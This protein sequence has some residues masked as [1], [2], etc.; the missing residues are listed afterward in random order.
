MKSF[1]D[2]LQELPGRGRLVA[3]RLQAENAA[4]M[5]VSL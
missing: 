3:G 5:R 2:D 4:W 1:A